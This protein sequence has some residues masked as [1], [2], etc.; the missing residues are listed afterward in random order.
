MG[1]Q[2]Y[3]HFLMKGSH[4]MVIKKVSIAIKGG[5]QIRGKKW[6]ERHCGDQ[7]VF[8]STIEWQLNLVA[9]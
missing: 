6:G 3:P 8:G 9:I 4:N 1:F 5:K 2:Q 7:K